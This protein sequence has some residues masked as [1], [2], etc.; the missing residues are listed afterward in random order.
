MRRTYT[1]VT[2]ARV[3]LAEPDKLHWGAGIIATTRIN[4][5]SV[6]P[7]LKR[8][9]EA[10]WVTSELEDMSEVHSRPPRRFHRLT[11]KGKL[12]LP[13]LAGGEHGQ[14]IRA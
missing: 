13:E 9:E 1:A 6:Y 12:E 2:I 7:I 11:E 14:E 3:L 8:M 4:P 5:G 10:G